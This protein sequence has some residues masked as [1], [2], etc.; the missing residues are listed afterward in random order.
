[1][2][3]IKND[4]REIVWVDVDWI[5]VTQSREGS[6]KIVINLRV[7]KSAWKFLSRWKTGGLSKKSSAPWI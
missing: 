7:P 4:F 3:N 2:D 1:V 5:Y 6:C